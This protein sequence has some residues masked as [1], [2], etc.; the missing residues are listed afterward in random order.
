[1]ERQSSMGSN[2]D[3]GASLGRIPKKKK[4]VA[5]DGTSTDEPTT[6]AA[7]GDEGAGDKKGGEMSDNATKHDKVPKKTAKSPKSKSASGSNNSLEKFD[8]PILRKGDLVRLSNEQRSGRIQGGLARITRPNFPPGADEHNTC[9]PMSYDIEYVLGGKVSNL[10]RCDILYTTATAEGLVDA[11]DSSRGHL[12]RRRRAA[13]PASETQDEQEKTPAKKGKKKTK[14]TPEK[15]DADDDTPTKRKGPGRP[16]SKKSA[17]RSKSKEKSDAVVENKKKDK[18]R[19]VDL[20]STAAKKRRSSK[21]SDTE[22]TASAVDIRRQAAKL[23]WEKRRAQEAAK[24]A[25]KPAKAAAKPAKAAVKPASKLV[26]KPASKSA[27]NK[28]ASKRGSKRNSATDL[29]EVSDATSTATPA[30]EPSRRQDL[31]TRHRK[32]MEKSL[33]RLEKLDRFGFFLD[34]TPPEFDE[35]YDDESAVGDDGL[36]QA[37][38]VRKAVQFP[39]H[40]PFNFLVVRKRLAAGMYDLDMAA[41]EQKRLSEIKAMLNTPATSRDNTDEEKQHNDVIY[42]DEIAKSMCHP[43]AVDWETLNADVIAMCDAAMIRD[44]DGISTGNGHLGWAASKIKKLMD[45]IYSTYG[46]KRRLEVEESEAREKYDKVLMDCANMEAAFQG[47]WRKEAFPERKYERLETSSVICHGL[48]PNDRSYAMYELETKLPD[49]FVGLAYTYDDSGQHSET[50]M[51]TVA[52]ET[53]Q[54]K[55]QKSKAKKK[56]KDATGDSDS[57]VSKNNETKAQKAAMALAKD[58]GVVRAQVQTAMTTLLIQVQDRVMTDLGVM[59]NPEAR[60]ANWDDGDHHRDYRGGGGEVEQGTHSGFSL[61]EVAEQEV[62]GIDCYTRKN[63]MS[64]IESEFTPQIAIEF[65][66][67]WLLPAINACPVDLAHK[68][69]TAAR[70]LE[71]L[72]PIHTA[73]KSMAML[74]EDAT[75]SA[76]DAIQLFED[77]NLSLDPQQSSQKLQECCF[78]LRNALDSKI[79]EHAPPWLKAA[80]R[81]VRLASDSLDDD[82]FRIHPKGHGSV[83]IGEDGLKANS[84]VTYYRGEVYPAWRWC[85]KLDAIENVQK[86]LNLRPN[87]PDFYNMA[88]ERPKKD[89]RGYCL[90]FVDASRKSGLGSSF[91][92]SCNPTC[93]VRVVS[94]NGKLSLSMTTLRDLELGEELTFDYNAVT[95]SVNEYRFAVCLCGQRKC[96]GSFLHFAT[97][98]CYQ[99]VLSRNSPISARFANLVRGCMKKVMSKEDSE[100]LLKHGFNTAVFGAVSFNHHVSNVDP[101]SSPDSIENVPVWLRTYVADCLRYIEYERRALP[102]ALLCN[103]MERMEKKQGKSKAPN[104]KK[105]K[106]LLSKES[107]PAKSKSI[108]GSKPMTSY[109]YFLQSQREHWESIARQEHGPELKGL[110]FSQAVNKEASRVWGNLNEEEKQSWKNKSIADW[111]KNGGKEKAKLEEERQRSLK[112]DP[113][114]TAKPSDKQKTGAIPKDEGKN[115]ENDLSAD[116]DGTIEAKTISFADADAEGCSAMEQRIQQLA[117]GLSRVGRVLDRHRESVFAEMKDCNTTVDSDVLRNLVPSPLKIMSDGE[118]VKWIW[119]DSKGV[120]PNLFSMTETHFPEHSL[121]RELLSSTKK[122]YPVLSAFSQNHAVPSLDKKWKHSCTSSDARRLVREAM[123]K[124]RTN[125]IEFLSFAE[126]SHAETRSEKR[127]EQ[128]RAREEKKKHQNNSSTLDETKSEVDDIDSSVTMPPDNN[129]GD[130][131]PLE[132]MPDDPSRQG[133]DDPSRQGSSLHDDSEASLDSESN[134]GDEAMPMRGGGECASTD[135]PNT[136]L[137]NSQMLSQISTLQPVGLDTSSGSSV[138]V[139]NGKLLSPPMVPSSTDTHNGEE[140]DM[141]GDKSGPTIVQSTVCEDVQSLLH[142]SQCSNKV[143][144]ILQANSESTELKEGKT[145]AEVGI[146]SPSRLQDLINAV[147]S[148]NDGGVES[149]SLASKEAPL[150]NGGNPSFTLTEEVLSAPLSAGLQDPTNAEAE[151]KKSK[152]KVVPLSEDQVKYLKDWLFDPKNIL[153][154]YPTDEEKSAIMKDTGIERKRLDGWFMKNRQK[155][156]YPEVQPVKMKW[157]KHDQDHWADFRKNRYMLEATADLLLM[158]ARTNTFFLLEPFRQFDS[159]PIEVYARELGNEVPHHFALNYRNSASPIPEVADSDGDVLM[160]NSTMSDKAQKS[161]KKIKAKK[162]TA[163]EFCTPDEV[164]DKVTVDYSG[165]YVLSQLLQ[166]VNGGMGQKKGLPDIYG[167]VML[168][169][170]TGCWEEIKCS[171]VKLPNY[172]RW[173]RKTTTEYAA[174]ERPKLAEWMVDRYQ[175][176]SPWDQDLAKYFCPL[177][178]AAPDPTVPMGSPVL[179]YLVTGIDEN[180]RQVSAALSGRAQ[181]AGQER[182][183]LSASDRLQSTVDE[184]MPAQAVANWVQCENPNCLKWRKLPWHVDV[185]LLPENFFCKDNV[186][187]PKSQSCEASEDE[188]DMEDAPVKFDTNDEHFEVGVWFDVQREGKVGYHEAQVIDVDFESNVKR[189][190]FH[191]WKLSSDRD[192]WVEVGSPKIAPHHSYTPRPLD[193]YETSKK[194]KNLDKNR[195]SNNQSSSNAVG[196]LPQKRKIDDLVLSNPSGHAEGTADEHKKFAIFPE[197]TIDY[198]NMWLSQHPANPFPSTSEKAKIVA[199]TGLSKRQVGDWMARARKKL[200]KTSSP[201]KGQPA[202]KPSTDVTTVKIIQS[203]PTKVENLLLALRN[204]TS[205]PQ[206][207]SLVGDQHVQGNTQLLL[208]SRTIESAQEK[209]HVS[210]GEV[211]MSAPIVGSGGETQKTSI[212]EL[213]IFMQTWLS[214]PENAGNLMPSLAQKEKIIQE[215]GIQKKRLEGW[216]F[217]ARKKLKKQ[218]ETGNESQVSQATPN[219][220]VELASSSSCTAPTIQQEQLLKKPNWENY[221]PPAGM[222]IS[223]MKASKESQ[224]MP[225]SPTKPGKA[226]QNTQTSPAKAEIENMPTSAMKVGKANQSLSTSAMKAVKADV[227]T[228]SL[229]VGKASH[230]IPISSSSSPPKAKPLGLSEE[231]KTYLA[232]W[233]SEHSSNPYPSKEEKN[234]MIS[235]LGIGDARKLEGWFCRARKRQKLKSSSNNPDQKSVGFKSQGENIMHAP[236]RTNEM[237]MTA[238]SSGSAFVDSSQG[239]SQGSFN[240]ASLL[241]AAKSE[242]GESSLRSSPHLHASNQVM[243][244]EPMIHHSQHPQQTQMPPPYGAQHGFTPPGGDRNY[245][246]LGAREQAILSSFQ[247]LQSMEIQDRSSR[248]AS[249]ADSS[250]FHQPQGQQQ[251][252]AHFSSNQHSQG[253]SDQHSQGQQQPSPTEYLSYQRVQG[254]QRPSPAEY[255]SNQHSQGPSYQHSQVQQRHSPAEYASHQHPRVQHR[256]SPTEHLPYPHTQGQQP[257][258]YPSYQQ[259]QCQ[260]QAP[261][262]NY[263]PHEHPQGQQR[264]SPAE[265]SYQQSQGQHHASPAEYPNYQHVEGQQQGQGNVYPCPQEAHQGHMPYGQQ[266]QNSTYQH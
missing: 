216:F 131:G 190:K 87:L 99:Q 200:R 30:D 98:D 167:C 49:S 110:E 33:G 64:M 16:P 55:P 232:R 28:T 96:R 67:K 203:S 212:K 6:N 4:F 135:P 79:K 176:G 39:D 32:E 54:A 102:V 230:N 14:A 43:L 139:N 26:S 229:N 175:R 217:R 244:D 126:K 5:S 100:L 248:R 11:T 193:G 78:F 157:R 63:V 173:N 150:L 171:E 215:T 182:S 104:P 42:Y 119:S 77:A 265:Y 121:L 147:A 46:N 80:A 113:K 123:L 70:I 94:L 15:K 159:T 249:P 261:A 164:V 132:N 260:Q 146:P 214:R 109:F 156:L 25:A 253:P 117:Q 37:L 136:G 86:Q 259:S 118:V 40:P 188:W 152:K 180:I 129:N 57:L 71:G 74:P 221:V 247:S 191:F 84:L 23:G 184:G 36:E 95:E 138:E 204:Q 141:G 44:P 130:I 81:L 236:S 19:K 257:A 189:I 172:T 241:S 20:T 234:A 112:K 45:E 183:K 91:S 90:L 194:K 153:N 226:S 202:D 116:N 52:D 181:T 220:T 50:W 168:P 51:K 111:K 41:L 206:Q 233:L 48:S 3:K 24:A 250:S 155:V 101:Q 255:A 264:A 65:V 134:M 35:N 205:T 251:D 83:V 85:E 31:Y 165:E 192:A 69:S 47:N 66:E 243:E 238:Q 144:A 170:I 53:S 201:D 219:S 105:E 145:L 258:E 88:M 107:S 137:F 8:P 76:N 222:N 149:N 82:N 246:N 13:A 128:A 196:T 227:P 262:A 7:H 231:A 198:L 160:E 27:N 21:T 225:T 210:D 114:E 89:P 22:S 140:S 178:Q 151:T 142:L 161:T 218:L 97:A 122:C 75:A 59:H 254:Q 199:D 73:A 124:L 240:F 143:G 10:D 197:T 61:P 17:S 92:H 62:W 125:I 186:W 208:P 148:N 56:K 133:S 108:A 211:G 242:L 195:G 154:P 263:S 223:P 162:E 106:P 239:S 60:S 158:Y 213:E 235:L 163:D 207:N 245:R 34:T 237:N 127:R 72:P 252:V 179:D 9:E 29:S 177:D 228:S 58:D 169:P 18:E 2:S 38:N 120:V 1:M 68:M 115:K 12:L 166:W 185:D 266:H 174:N 224:S 209:S 187:N 93:E 103:Q 256:A